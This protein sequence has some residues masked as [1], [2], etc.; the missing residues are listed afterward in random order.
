MTIV[1]VA[2]YEYYT[3]PWANLVTGVLAF[4]VANLTMTNR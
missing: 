1:T 2:H 3:N 4:Q